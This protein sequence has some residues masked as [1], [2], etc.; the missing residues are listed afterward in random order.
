MANPRVDNAHG[1]II[2]L[3]DA[4]NDAGSDA[5]SW[6]FFVLAGAGDGT[7][8]STLDPEDLFGSPDGL[9][10]D[11][12]GVMWIQT[13]GGQ[14]DGSNNQML[15]CDLTTGEIRRFL[16]GPNDCEVTGVALTPDRSTI[17]INIQHPGDDG[18]A[19]D[20]TATS[21]WPDGADATLPRP[22]TVA[23]RRIDN[24]MIGT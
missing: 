10:I 13:D 20:P 7:D 21:T 8:G 3:I 16:V 22:A 24:Q 14:P 15:A 4:D 23:I 19:D 18:T 6:D 9:V 2:W 12:R 5:F 1:H 17:F 11:S